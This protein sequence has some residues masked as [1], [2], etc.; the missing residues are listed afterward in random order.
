MSKKTLAVSELKLKKLAVLSKAYTD[1]EVAANEVKLFTKT[2][3]QDDYA[4]TYILAKGHDTAIITDPSSPDYG[5]V[6]AANL[7]GYINIPKDFLVKSGKVITVEAGQTGSQWEGKYV[8]VAEDGVVLPVA[9]QYEAPGNISA[10]GKYLDFV[11]NTKADGDGSAETDT[12]MIVAVND[13]VD[14][15]SGGNGINITDRVVSIDLTAN[16]GLEL[17]GATEGQKT[18][19]IKIYSTGGLQTDAN[20]LSVKVKTDGGLQTDANGTGIK[21]DQTVQGHNELKLTS[22]GLKFDQELLVDAELGSW[23][24]YAADSEMVTTTLPAVSSDSI[25]DDE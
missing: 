22:D 25:T 12:H 6:P 10:A 1:Q 7:I 15:Y 16:G 5:T 17:T 14:V 3:A 8:V 24:G 9:N 21:L 20:G 4:K 18:L 13:L 19:G 23:F 2:T 11:V